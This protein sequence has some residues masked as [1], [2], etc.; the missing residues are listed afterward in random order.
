MKLYF[1]TA[2]VAKCYLNE[3]D[4]AAVRKLARK[5]DTLYSS[6]LCSAEFACVLRRH[7]REGSLTAAARRDL[8]LSITQRGV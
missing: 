1:D 2:Y 6:S 5:A 7:L 8:S 3:P 4:R